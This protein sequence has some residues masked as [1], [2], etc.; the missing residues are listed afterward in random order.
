MNL[1]V[2]TIYYHIR[3]LA[4]GGFLKLS[5]YEE[6]HGG[7][8]K[9]YVPSSES[10]ATVV[11]PGA[12]KGIAAAKKSVPQPFAPFARHGFFDGL[13]V[14]GSPEPHGKYRA[15]ASELSVLELAMLLGSYATFSFP[16]Y[17][18]DTQLKAE[19]R[20]K[21]L[22]LAGGP[23]VNTLVAEINAYLPVRF[24]STLSK[25]RYSEN[26][27]VI[28]LIRS[29]FAKGASILLV[30][31]LNYHGTRAAVL[32]LVE[33][34]K[35]VEKGNTQKPEILAKVVE[36]FDENGDGMVDAVEVLE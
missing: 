36:G 9:R 14:V 3:L 26:I 11:K 27:G 19:D 16:L 2:Q 24:D 29:P 7:I 8:A 25:K 22:I 4:R 5:E 10:F 31:G 17:V 12:W 34:M 30:G 6:R 21:N 13:M 15:R 32:A 18:L 1:P 20:K 35:D 33:N 23:K 28:E